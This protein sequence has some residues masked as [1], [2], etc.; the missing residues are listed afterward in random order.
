MS[1]LPP[2]TKM[3][4][5]FVGHGNPMFAIQQNEFTAAWN[6]LGALL[7]RPQAI[8]CISAHWETSATYVTAMHQPRTIHDFGGFPRELH[9]VQYPAPGSPLLAAEIASSIQNINLD[10][11][12]WGLD[13]GTWSVM[14]NIYPNADIP[15][16]QMSL[17]NKLSPLEHYNLASQLAY[18]REKGVLIIGSGNLVHN[19]Q[20]INWRKEEDL[21]DWAKEANDLIKRWIIEGNM[22]DLM[23]YKNKGKAINLAIPTPEHFIPLIYILALRNESDKISFFNDKLLMGTLSM[24]SILLE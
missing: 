24:T 10:L 1:T 4:T 21:H 15:I 23:D 6:Q 11:N 13:H 9:E 2:S 16:V 7:P 3:P 14:K 20:L 8:M 22:V 12:S 17:N 5:L 19:L 18:L